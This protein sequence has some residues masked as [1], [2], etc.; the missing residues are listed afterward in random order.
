MVQKS[1]EITLIDSAFDKRVEVEVAM[2]LEA[3]RDALTRMNNSTEI[4]KS[5]RRLARIPQSHAG[6]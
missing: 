3:N 2:V 1:D 6:L 5:A 4:S